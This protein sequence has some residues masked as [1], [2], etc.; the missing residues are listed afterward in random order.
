M[1]SYGK[2]TAA[3]TEGQ[4]HIRSVMV[5]EKYVDWRINVLATKPG[6]MTAFIA[7]DDFAFHIS[8]TCEILPVPQEGTTTGPATTEMP[9]TTEIPPSL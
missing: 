2:A 6:D 4:V 3:W 5:D 7:V 1:W 9:G 8:D